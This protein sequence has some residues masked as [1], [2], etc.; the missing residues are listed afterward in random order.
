MNHAL[1]VRFRVLL[2]IVGLCL[3][4]N[5]AGQPLRLTAARETVGQYEKLEMTIAVERR[6]DNPFDHQEVELNV[7]IASEGGARW[8]VPGFYC[9]DYERKKL[10]G[11]RDRAN[12]YYP[13]GQG[14]WKAR[15]SLAEAG[16]HSAVAILKDSSGTVKSNVVRFKCESGEN[17]GFVTVSQKDPR[18]LAFSNGDPFF[19]IGQNLAF[20]GE[21]QYV[22]L[23]KAEQIF[24][25]MSKNGANFARIWTCCDDWAIAIE[26]PKS[27]WQRS[28][29]RNAPIVE[30]PGDAS[31]K[32]IK[33]E[34]AGGKSISVSPSHPVGLKPG[35]AYVLSGRFLSDGADGLRIHVAGR[36][37]D[38]DAGPSNVW[39]DFR[40]AF[41]T[42]DD[43]MWLGRLTLAV[44]GS[45]MIRL[46]GL[47]LREAGGGAELLW[48]ANVNR[49][50]RGVYNQLDCFMLDELIEAAEEDDIYLMLCLI[51]R[52][53]YMKDLSEVGSDAYQQA[54]DD[55]K[56]LMRYVIARWGY[57]TSVAAWEYFNEMDPGKPTD[58]FY[59]EVGRYVKAADIY[60]HLR[61]TSTWHP[62]A[63]DCRL[64]SL[65]I[66]Q[67][68][69]YM[70][71]GTKEN[72]QDAVASILDKAAFLREHAPNKPA[73][74]GEFGLADEK[75][76]R[77]NYMK[78]DTEGV[79]FH[80]SLW[81]SAFSGV[82]G[83]A[84]FW[85]WEVLDAQGAYRHYKPLGEFFTGVSLAGLDVVNE[86]ASGGRV[87]V[88]GYRGE[89]RA[90]FW[91]SDSEATWWSRVVEEQEPE[92]VT[93]VDIRISGLEPGR[94][95]VRWWDTAE[96]KPLGA[97][98]VSVE[99]PA[100][101]IG[102]PAFRGDIACAIVR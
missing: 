39:K 38:F 43:Q 54:V 83:T 51:T 87:R 102:V 70:R 27:A 6:Y 69:H 34:G 72:M 9:Q 95:M 40:C 58:R 31:R 47:S 53:L 14:D 81:A 55:A 2:L 96:G 89:R 25:R 66:A 18:Y 44:R 68:H 49:P 80:N 30:M 76:G 24:A 85:W 101:E 15:L 86:T 22:N 19:A 1:V 92:S 13:V 79:H 97:D 10:D 50:V 74:I 82:S 3:T 56:A 67:L 48:E 12:W 65:D 100:V 21:G 62:S 91:L 16:D 93:G 98:I 57:S 71:P 99:G 75:W 84:M 61:T 59:N 26:A 33:I 5:A 36:D 7:E 4:V 77:S 60:G 63:R 64:D 20:V 88:L 32:C 29:S 90:Y 94:Y 23:S 73:L 52:D 46:D 17:K 35:T 37:A 78:E 41:T 42:A 8:I 11:G 45:G 28:W